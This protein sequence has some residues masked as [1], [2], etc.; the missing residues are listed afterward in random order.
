MMRLNSRD[1]AP[2]DRREAGAQRD[3]DCDQPSRR[4]PPESRREAHRLRAPSKRQRSPG[5]R[6]MRPELRRAQAVRRP[7]AGRAIGSSSAA[8]ASCR[9]QPVRLE[10]IESRATSMP[11]RLCTPS[12][13]GQRPCRAPTIE[14]GCGTLRRRSAGKGHHAK[15]GAP[16][17]R[18]KSSWLI[19]RL[20]RRWF[21]WHLMT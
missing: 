17:S 18:E 5:A 4:P 14:H 13:D 2:G 20:V 3:R 10:R 7:T 1:R 9:T 6:P 15:S 16:R 19:S 21:A 12:R 8:M 11:L